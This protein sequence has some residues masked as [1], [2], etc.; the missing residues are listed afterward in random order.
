MNIKPGAFKLIT[1]ITALAFSTLTISSF[2]ALAAKPA[3]MPVRVRLITREIS[4]GKIQPGEVEYS[5]ALS[6]DKKHIAYTVKTKDGEFVAVDGVA[7][8]TYTNDPVAAVTLIAQLIQS[9]EVVSSRGLKLA[10][11]SLATEF[12]LIIAVAQK[13]AGNL[14]NDSRF[15]FPRVSFQFGTFGNRLSFSSQ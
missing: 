10:V 15:S 11:G 8:K 4:L 12:D 14:Q 13:P 9:A 7:R 3:H 1:S 2:F 6:S 5:R